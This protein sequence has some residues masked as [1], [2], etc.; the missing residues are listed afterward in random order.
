MNHCAFVLSS[1][2]DYAAKHGKSL[3]QV[4]AL[5][6]LRLQSVVELCIKKDVPA[7]S[8][9]LPSGSQG[10][11]GIEPFLDGLASWSVLHENQV[12]VSVLGSWLSLPESV[13]SA[14]RKLIDATKEYDS[15][16][17]NLCIN[18]DGRKDLLEAVSSIARLVKAGKLDP[19]LLR[20]AHLKDSLSTS[21][22]LPPDVI[23]LAGTDALRG[24]FIWDSA[25]SSL[26]LAPHFCDLSVNDLERLAFVSH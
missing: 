11:A 14:V 6:L 2:D 3:A 10:F 1:L 15:F 16:F 7:T 22:V 12:R 5:A 21:G 20:E 13:T 17:L 4:Y 23:V 8:F 24:F 18:Y 9:F 25:D 26:V 19:E